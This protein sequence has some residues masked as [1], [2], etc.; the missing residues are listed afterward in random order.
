LAAVVILGMAGYLSL[1]ILAGDG[2]PESARLDGSTLTVVNAEGKELWRKS[3]PEGFW[4]SY[5]AQGVAP[6]IRFA[7]LEGSGHTSVLLLYH[8]AVSPQSRSTTLICYSDQGKEKWRWTPGRELPELQ[9]TPSN[10]MAAGIEVLRAA[11][12]QRALRIVVVSNHSLYY[13]AQVAIVDSNGKTV[14]EYWHSGHLDSFMLAD[15]EEKGNE[16]IIASGIN[17]GYHQATVIIL[18]PERVAGASTEL[19]RPDVQIHGMGKGEEKA[20]L[21][22]P[23]SDLN[24]QLMPYNEAE[25]AVVGHGRIRVP[26]HECDLR[27]SCDIGYEFDSHLHLLAVEPYD[28]FASARREFYAKTP[29]AE[30]RITQTMI[31]EYEKVRC[32]AGCPAEFVAVDFTPAP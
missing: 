6:R 16:E 3:F 15:P 9:G 18:D 1:R 22:F 25:E 10:Y 7:D 30:L 20:R 13:P 19:E 26:V 11:P 23:R 12:G 21:I 31:F 27:P 2:R 8:P 32:L 24:R 14:S 17:N 5:Y 29:G 4:P 28:A